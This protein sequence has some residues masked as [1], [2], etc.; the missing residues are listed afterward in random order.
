MD[1][2]NFFQFQCSFH[3][4]SI[5]NRAPKIKNIFCFNQAVRHLRHMFLFSKH[6]FN[7]LRQLKQSGSQL[8]H[9][10]QRN[11]LFYLPHIES[12][13]QKGNQLCSICFC[14]CHG[15]FRAGQ[16]VNGHICFTGNG[17]SDGICHRDTL[18]TKTLCFFQSRQCVDRF[19]GLADNDT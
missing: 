13:H 3:G 11:T 1:I 19:T 14:R 16:C 8:L 7:L 4:N 6:F 12:K 5:V 18:G 10:F 2:R 15:N 17:R 9:Q